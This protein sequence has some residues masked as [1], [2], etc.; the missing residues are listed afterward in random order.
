M[1]LIVSYVL[2]LVVLEAQGI[3]SFYLNRSDVVKAAL[4]ING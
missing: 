3:R 4:L 1:L 2:G